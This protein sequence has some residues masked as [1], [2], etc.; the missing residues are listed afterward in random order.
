MSH[1][2]STVVIKG[3]N[4]ADG[5]QPAPGHISVV[6]SYTHSAGLTDEHIN[7]NIAKARRLVD[8]LYHLEEL[9]EERPEE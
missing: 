3:G 1:V 2:S 4:Y 5:Q 9:T 6:V 7:K 8:K